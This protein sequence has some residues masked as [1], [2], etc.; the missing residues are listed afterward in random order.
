MHLARA[1]TKSESSDCSNYFDQQGLSFRPKRAD[2]FSSR[3]LPANA[4]ARVVEESLFDPSRS[5]SVPGAK[6]HRISFFS[7]SA[8]LYSFSILFRIFSASSAFGYKS[9]YR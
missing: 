1:F 9:K 5:L 3:S 2:A 8:S 6:L 7:F 4:S